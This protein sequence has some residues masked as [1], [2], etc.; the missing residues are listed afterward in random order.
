[1]TRPS[2]RGRGIG[3]ALVRA[4]EA[5]AAERGRTLLVLDTAS[6]GRAAGLYEQLGYTFAGEIPG[7]ALTPYGALSGTRIYWKRLP[8][9]P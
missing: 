5:Q 2:H 4:A 9:S 3:A 8:P 7:Y 1:M 6:D